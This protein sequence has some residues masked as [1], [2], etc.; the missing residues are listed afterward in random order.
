[1][2]VNLSDDELFT[3]AISGYREAFLVQHSHL[4]ELERNQ[5]WI[6]RLSQFIPSCDRNDWNDWKPAGNLGKRTRQDATPRTLPSDAGLPRAKRRA[7][8]PELPVDLMRHL[9]NASS[10]DL[11]RKDVSSVGHGSYRHTAMVR[12][13]SQQIPVSH[14]HQPAGAVMG[15]RQSFGPVQTQRR[16]DHVDEYS[17]SEYTRHLENFP[18]QP[19]DSALT[20]GLANHGRTGPSPYPQYSGPTPP[21]TDQAP[22]GAAEMSRSGTTDSLVCGI[23]MFRVDSNGPSHQEPIDSIPPE[24]VPTSNSGLPYQSPFLSVY[25][26]LDPP[27]SLPYSHPTS[28]STSAPATTS[29][30]YRMPH[31]QHPLGAV[32]MKFSDSIDSNNSA[33]LRSRASRRAQEQI[34]HGAR[35][36]APKRES[37]SLVPSLDSIDPHKIVRISSTD[38][39]A[40][41]VAA[42]PKASVQRP[43][44]Q[45]TYCHICNDQPDGFHGEHELRRHIERVH[46]SI[47]RVWVCV[48]ISPDKSFLANCKA[49][50]NGKRYGANYNAAAHLRRTHF[51]PC[52]RGRGGR[53]KDSEKRGGKGGGNSPSMDVLKH[54]MVPTEEVASDGS[55]ATATQVQAASSV[56]SIDSGLG[57][58]ASACAIPDRSSYVVES[59]L[60]DEHDQFPEFP[61]APFELDFEIGLDVDVGSSLN[62]PFSMDSQSSYSP[63]FRMSCERS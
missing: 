21:W 56:P 31:P 49:C 13:Q 22:A 37:D 30:H 12:S 58:A 29:F 54:W 1:M 4:S 40:K 24:W 25:P 57:L 26:D 42:I 23:N 2:T 63:G 61:D 20:F 9:S 52:Q 41:E 33:T 27:M 28:F 32:D 6:E 5:L 17:P 36:I 16:L 55:L 44:R 38:G 46:A 10:P 34:A 39:T 35:P 62:S 50:R 43:P 59:A 45:K 53:G 48:D 7:T 3:S 19:Y 60:I 15:K 11:P 18:S 8:T 14:R 47:R 51:N